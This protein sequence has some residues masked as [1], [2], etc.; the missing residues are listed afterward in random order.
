MKKLLLVAALGFGPWGFAAIGPA[1]AAD[2]ALPV[3]APPPPPWTWTGFYIGGNGGYSWG[4]WDST[5]LTAI[6]PGPGGTLVNSASP[7]VQG[8]IAGGQIG[9][10]WQFSPQWLAGVEADG[11]WSGE[12]ASDNAS[13][14]ISVAGPFTGACD[15]AGGCTTTATVNDANSW[16]LPWFAT[17]RGRVGLIE[18][19]TWLFYATGGLAVG[20]A[21]F[22]QSSIGT[23]TVTKTLSGTVVST[24][25]VPISALS[26]TTTVVGF[27]VGAGIEKMLTQNWSLKV[28]YLFMDFGSYTFLSGTGFDTNVKVIDNVIRGGVNYK[29]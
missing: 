27:A 9:Y 18:E 29:F 12:R 20:G 19:S 25:T 14:S 10:N 21:Q 28:E 17:L 16:K 1:Q 15:V 23:V 13:S 26:G 3:K 7:N 2:M 4:N 5:S 24:T 8:A 11:Q 22:A 6:F